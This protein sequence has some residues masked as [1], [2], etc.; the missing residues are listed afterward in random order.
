MESSPRVDPDVEKVR[1]TGTYIRTSIKFLGKGFPWNYFVAL[2]QLP[3]PLKSVNLLNLH[4]SFSEIP[5]WS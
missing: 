4:S 3:S 1:K 5:K 2:S